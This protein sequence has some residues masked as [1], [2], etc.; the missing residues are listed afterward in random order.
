[1]DPA[2]G[3]TNTQPAMGSNKLAGVF[4]LKWQPDDTFNVVVRAD[5]SAEHDTGSTYH[6]LGISSAP[7][8]SAGKTS[9]CNIPA[10]CVGF[11]DL[12]RP[13]HRALLSD[14]HGDQRLRPQF[15]PA[16]YN[17]LLN[18]LA[19]E[20]AD[21]FWTMDQAISN[22]DVGHYRTYSATANKSSGDIDVKLMARLS[23]LGQYRHRGQPR[24]ALRHQ[25]SIVYSMPDYQS[26]QSELT[27]NGKALDDKLKWTSGPVLLQRAQPQ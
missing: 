16:A 2:T 12:L 4:S 3:R 25:R 7:S 21:G 1:M 22:A 19:R 24:P 11:T 26:W 6:D 13:Y 10:T 27:V 23:R 20:Q 17:S 8:L 18:S 15:F 9:I 5:I 14:R